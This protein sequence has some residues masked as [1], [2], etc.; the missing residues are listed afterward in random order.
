MSKDEEE[1]HVALGDPAL[2]YGGDFLKRVNQKHILARARFS[3]LEIRTC[4]YMSN[5]TPIDYDIIMLLSLT[6]SLTSLI[7]VYDVF[8]DVA[9]RSY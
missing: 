8:H 6:A 4:V 5:V 9:N 1:V 2:A 7:S 3:R